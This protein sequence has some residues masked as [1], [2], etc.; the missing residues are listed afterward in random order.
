MR[1]IIS[2][3]LYACIA[4]VV[5]SS[6]IV[7]SES[8]AEQMLIHK[9]TPIYKHKF[10]VDGVEK[11]YYFYVVEKMSICADGA[12][13]AYNKDDTGLDSLA[14]AGFPCKCWRNVLIPDPDDCTIPYARRTGKYKDYYISGTKLS[15]ETKVEIDEGK[16]V[17]ATEIPY[18]VFPGKI[19]HA[20]GTGRFGDFGIA[21]NLNKKIPA[22]FIVA[23]LGGEDDDLGE[24]SIRLAAMLGG[25]NPNPRN[26]RGAPEGK[27]LYVVFPYS[28]LSPKWPHTDNEIKDRVD[29]LVRSA[30]GLEKIIETYTSVSQ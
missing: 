8:T 26:G 29:E 24:V 28:E 6:S 9:N 30:G 15:D 2:I 16:Y 10:I 19:F 25:T 13:D 23:E 4:I 18:I 20:R 22:H 12:P 14:N 27:I 3:M 1:I 5:L 21:Y 11:Y 17:N 7:Y